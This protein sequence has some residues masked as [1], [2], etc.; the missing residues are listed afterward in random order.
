VEEREQREERP[1]RQEPDE[2]QE[3]EER[4]E[5]EPGAER[6]R[7]SRAKVAF[8]VAPLLAMVAANYVGDALTTT[9][10]DQHPLALIALNSRN[11]ILVLTTNQLDSLGYYGVASLRLLLSDPLFFLLGVWYGDSA[12]GWVERK[13]ASQGEVL[14]MFERAFGK[15]SYPLVFVAPNN[16]ICLLAGA[17]G[18]AVP[19][20]FALNVAGTLARLYA[21]RVLGATFESPID[22]VLD[23]F[24][25]Y[26]VP[27]LIASVVLVVVSFLADRRRGGGDLEVIRELEHELEEDPDRDRN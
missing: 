2:R 8:V 24:A 13:W 10:A 22:S 11:R 26:R 5:R 3:L 1:E 12:I 6:S 15:A 19:V 14:R 20:F 9:W 18:M 21:I 7:P 4:D 27:L 23:I 16:A 25:E 17:T